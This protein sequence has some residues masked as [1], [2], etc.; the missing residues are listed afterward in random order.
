MAVIGLDLGGTK[1]SGGLFA[2][3][4]EL[5]FKDSCKLEKRTGDEVGLLIQEF[6]KY[7][8]G[9]A[10]KIKITVYAVGICIP[11]ISYHETGCVWAPNIEGWENYPIRE[12]I[13]DVVNKDVKVIVDSDRACAIFGESWLGA[14]KDCA[15]VIFLAVGTGIGAGIIVNNQLVRGAHD[16]AGAIGWWALDTPFQEKFAPCGC[17]EYHASGEGIAKVAREIL[18]S[19]KNYNGILSK[20]N[21]DE[22]TS[23]DIFAAY[24]ENDDIAK[25]TIRTAIM[26][27]GMAVANLVSIF[28]PEKIIFGGGVFGPAIKF[29]DDIYEEAKKHAQP[30]SIQKVKLEASQLGNETVLI[31]AGYMALKAIECFY[32]P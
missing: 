4:G 9:E 28:D 15:N 1:L 13:Q 16:I 27:W 5:L 12:K 18:A 8:L 10:A 23:H 11:G 29:I 19:D 7:L 26:F 30:I 6:V 31:G 22:I 3:N 32:K 21:I 24:N 25:R 20:K 14:A 17:F 2:E